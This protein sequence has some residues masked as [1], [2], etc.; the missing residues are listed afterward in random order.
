MRSKLAKYI[1]KLMNQPNAH[2]CIHTCHVSVVIII[3]SP[4]TSN[5][6]H[7]YI[8]QHLPHS[9]SHHTE[10]ASR[11]WGFY[12]DLICHQFA[13][14]KGTLRKFVTDIVVTQENVDLGCFQEAGQ[15]YRAGS[16]TLTF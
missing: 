15:S 1:S 11:L 2:A 3:S 9:C 5:R 16:L 6:T 10:N 4:V 14:H 13:Q 8:S 7:C 12:V